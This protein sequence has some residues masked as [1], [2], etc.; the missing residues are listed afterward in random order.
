M[1]PRAGDMGDVAS[2]RGGLHHQ[3]GPVQ[4]R[5]LVVPGGAGVALPCSCIDWPPYAQR[6]T[7]VGAPPPGARRLRPATTAPREGEP[8]PGRGAEGSGG[9]Q[10]E[11]GQAVRGAGARAET[12]HAGVEEVGIG[13][14]GFVDGITKARVLLRAGPRATGRP[15]EGQDDKGDSWDGLLRRVDTV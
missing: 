4:F 9:R 11:R 12:I 6:P 8:V 7:P 3:G 5:A 1:P 14:G 13:A 2:E 10:R 15:R